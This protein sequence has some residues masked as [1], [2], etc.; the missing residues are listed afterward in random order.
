MNLIEKL[1]GIGTEAGAGVGAC[2]GAGVGSA[3]TGVGAGVGAGIGAG[4]G[5]M[6]D[7][8]SGPATQGSGHSAEILCR[9]VWKSSNDET[10]VKPGYHAGLARIPTSIAQTM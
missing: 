10:A 9:K 8:S 5:S 2:I 7:V 4:V 6:V 3:V 1:P